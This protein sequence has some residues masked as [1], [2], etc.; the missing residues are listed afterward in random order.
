[1][2]RKRLSMSQLKK[3]I[4]ETLPASGASRKRRNRRRRKGAGAASQ[5]ISVPQSQGVIV[6]L[7]KPISDGRNSF[8]LERTESA[9]IVTQ[10]T[11]AFTVLKVNL[12]PP[13]FGW[14]NQIAAAFS[15]WRWLQLMAIYIPETA[16]T[17]PGN[18]SMG[19][20]YDITDALPVGN[21]GMSNLDGYTSAPPWGGAPGAPLLSTRKS[22]PT[23]MPAGA[24]ATCLDTKRLSKPWYPYK[25]IPPTGDDGN[26]YSPGQLVVSALGSGTTLR[27]GEI[28]VRY[29]IELTEPT[30]PTTNTSLTMGGNQSLSQGGS[31]DA[32]RSLQTLSLA[33]VKL[34]ESDS[35]KTTSG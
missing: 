29:R 33:P 15:K 26:I 4:Q 22:W 23:S 11:A 5:A 6:R 35:F 10:G 12:I 8:L 31:F 32:A 21:A 9:L 2:D 25:A 16:S 27:T 7:N 13:S 18:V 24:V 34:G 1:M 3:A 19:F 14:I 17:T 20:T 28:Y 30:A